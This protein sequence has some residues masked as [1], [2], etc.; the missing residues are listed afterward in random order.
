MIC[1]S[2]LVL[3]K[4]QTRNRFVRSATCEYMADGHGKPT[5]EFLELYK[6]LAKGNIGIIISGFA[7]VMPNGKS[8]P[9]QSGI[10]DDRLIPVWKEVTGIVRDSGSVFL[11]QIVHAGRQVRQAVNCKEIWAPSAIPDPKYKSQPREMT[12]EQIKEV[13]AAFI[14][15]AARAE[16]AGF[17]GI[18]LHVAH[19]YLLSQFLSPY[20]NRRTDEYGGTQENRT[21]IVKEILDGIKKITGGSFIIS[22][23]IN[24]A[25]FLDGGLELDQAVSS[26]LI[27]KHA[28]I[29]FVE[30]SRGMSESTLGPVPK[31]SETDDLEGYIRT[32][33]AEIRRATGLPTASVGGY[34]SL[35][36][37]EQTLNAGDAD[38]ISLCR[39][40]IREPDLLLKF[41]KNETGKSA[42]ISCNRCFN[43]R[44]IR[45]WHV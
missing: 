36:F 2:P 5:K 44:G 26:A 27:M 42:C 25:D 41:A 20:T 16:E 15:S 29:D 8:N 32:G 7:Y 9:G 39:P 38:L 11:M 33:A 10:Y 12:R 28:G 22:A 18:Q 3:K 24:C 40:L 4:F 21:R 45:C 19:G 6:T 13:I 1:F 43:P 31:G 14:Q 30:V 37:M 17:H 23:K 35:E 34:R